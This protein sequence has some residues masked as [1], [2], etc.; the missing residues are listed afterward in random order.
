MPISFPNDGSTQQGGTFTSG[1]T[2]Y[3]NVNQLTLNTTSNTLLTN[4]N[5]KQD[6]LTASTV[7]LGNGG[8]ITN[9]NWNNIAQNKPTTFASDW[10]TLAN[11]PTA[12]ASDWSTLANKPTTFNPDLT[13]IYS[14]TQ[15]DNITTLANFYTKTS[16]DA[17]LNAKQNTL[18]STCNLVGI[19]SAITALNYNNITNAPNLSGYAT[20]S[21]L[22]SYQPL[23]TGSTV[24]SGIG[25]NLTLINYA[26][27]SNLPNLSQ[28][29]T[30]SITGLTNY[31]TTTAMN[32]AI[33]T[34]LTPYLTS[35]TAGT[36]YATIAN[37]NTKENALTFNTPFTRAT[38]TISID[39]SAYLTTATAS[40]TYATIANLNTKENVLTFNAPLTRTTNTISLDLSSY[41]TITARN[42]ALGGYLALTGGTLT[43]TL[44]GTT[45][46]ATTFNEGGT[47]LSSKYLSSASLAN[48]V[49]KAGD[50]MTGNLN[51]NT[52]GTN[53]AFLVLNSGLTSGTGQAGIRIFAGYGAINRA[54]RIDFY[55]NVIST[56][57]PRWT[58]INDTSQNGTNDLQFQSANTSRM[59]ILSGGNIGI[60]TNSPGALLDL[61]SAIQLLPKLQFTGQEYYQGTNNVVGVGLAFLL[62][63]NRANNRQLWI[64][65]NTNYS[66]TSTTAPA[67]R[68][69]V[70]GTDGTID[71]LAT[72]GTTRLNFNVGGSILCQSD[73]KVGIGL[74]TN[75]ALAKLDVR[76]QINSESLYVVDSN[77]YPTTVNNQYGLIISPPS[78]SAAAQITTIQ[79][80]FGFGQRLIIQ[81]NAN[82]T[83]GIGTI[84]AYNSYGTF[85]I[86]GSNTT[87][88][89]SFLSM[90]RI[91]G[92]DPNTIWQ[93]STSQPNICLTTSSGSANIYHSIGNGTIKT[94]TNSSGFGINT[95]P[96][97]PLTVNNIVND[98][99]SY[100]HSANG[101][102][103]TFTNQIS[104]GGVYNDAKPVLHLCR[105]GQGGVAYGARATFNLSRY[106]NVSVYSR[107]RMDITMAHDGYSDNNVM[108][109]YSDGETTLNNRMVITGGISTTFNVSASTGNVGTGYSGAGLLYW[110]AGND[111]YVVAKNFSAS[112]IISLYCYYSIYANSYISSSD[113]RI[114]ENIKPIEDVKEIIEKLV[115]VSYNFIET[116]QKSSGFIAQEVAEV[117]PDAVSATKNFL[118]NILEEAT[119]NGNV[120][121]FANTN[122]IKLTAHN[123]VK[124]AKSKIELNM[125]CGYMIT[126]VIDDNTF[127]ILDSDA[128]N[129]N[130]GSIYLYGMLVDDY[131]SIDYNQIIALNTKAIKDL[132]KII[133]RQQE[134]INKL[135]NIL[136]TSN[137][138]S[139]L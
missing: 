27:L 51:I 20:I 29:I 54:S 21:S 107:S 138:I 88:Y 24:L 69:G 13:N 79:Q 25:S 73:G 35:S 121:T 33:S 104:T 7:L 46:N 109:F 38:N 45:I 31:S 48:Y 55:N 101:A 37:L 110:G 78:S 98:R 75:S 17:L 93:T 3:S 80:G 81:G 63:V 116:K 120:I 52:T 122:N 1:S 14:K 124:I 96:N 125:A 95:S 128:R 111:S 137:I 135:T 72:N 90:L 102:V 28:Y 139:P 5:N 34:A 106:E 49:L 89:Y 129:F 10:S 15:V 112:P 131:S 40:T 70:S 64:V 50:T 134:Q 59:T 133:D 26:T 136:I 126:D 84:G 18:N 42:S 123:V 92:N 30:A 41:D 6:T 86:G 114:K 56:T 83:V 108:T 44:T 103:A 100:D 113:K 12:F 36:T 66:T 19:G 117:Y 99:G 71:C 16:T 118:P 23:L 67:I 43:G 91:C 97:S 4:I 62:G 65:D 58:I 105:Q 87:M 22:S 53:E 2:F 39:L 57:I 94:T 82:S 127:T 11:K 60:G 47:A 61:S 74:G 68:L 130:D 76:G 119:I 32:S 8:S 85:D 9:I 77:S 115:P 132:Y